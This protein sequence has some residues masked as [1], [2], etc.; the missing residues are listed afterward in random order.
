MVCLSLLTLLTDRARSPATGTYASQRPSHLHASA[1]L[2]RQKPNDPRR[3][4]QAE[5]DIERV[6]Q[7]KPAQ[8]KD[9]P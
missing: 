3:D 1:E 5:P 8:D 7:P 9:A 6:N 2:P 4:R